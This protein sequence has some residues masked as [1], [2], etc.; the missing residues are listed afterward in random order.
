MKTLEHVLNLKPSTS[1]FDDYSRSLHPLYNERHLDLRCWMTLTSCFIGTPDS[2]HYQKHIYSVIMNSLI[3]YIGFKHFGNVSLFPLM[4]RIVHR[5]SSKSEKTIN[6]LQDSSLSWTPYRLRLLAQTSS[7]YGMRNTDHVHT[8]F[9]FFLLPSPRDLVFFVWIYC[10]NK[11]CIVYRG[12]APCE[13]FPITNPTSRQ[14]GKFYNLVFFLVYIVM[15]P[16][17]TWW[18]L[19]KQQ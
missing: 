12:P 8:I 9:S 11:L 1:G 5:T 7:F 2:I 18:W 6:D 13:N 3:S 4:I 19:S 16:R 10:F 14:I 15:I 17:Y